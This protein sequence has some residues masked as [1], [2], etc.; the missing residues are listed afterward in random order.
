MVLDVDKIS[1]WDGWS[2]LHR[3]CYRSKPWF[4][5]FNGNMLTA[6]HR[7][8]HL[9]RFLQSVTPLNELTVTLDHV[10]FGVLSSF[11]S[12]LWTSPRPLSV[13]RGNKRFW[14]ATLML[15][16]GSLADSNPCCNAQV[17]FVCLLPVPS[18]IACWKA[19]MLLHLT[20]YRWNRHASCSV[21]LFE[22][23]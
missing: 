3:T 17:L 5:H 11:N 9:Q 15:Q 20:C 4:N 22:G 23:L 21:R 2:L 19:L 6:L 1:Y 16:Y 14:K 8:C 13:V 10:A 18:I 12:G 7:I